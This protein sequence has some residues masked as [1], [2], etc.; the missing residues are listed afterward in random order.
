MWSGNRF[1]N[2]MNVRT[3]KASAKSYLESRAT[4]LRDHV[5]MQYELTFIKSLFFIFSLT[6]TADDRNIATC[7]LPFMFLAKIVRR[8]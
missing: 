7:I 4:Q 1:I 8:Q 6:L 3:D 2:A 5:I